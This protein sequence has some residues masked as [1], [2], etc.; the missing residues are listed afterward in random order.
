MGQPPPGRPTTQRFLSDR[1]L[2]SVFGSKN[3]VASGSVVFVFMHR[4]KH[5]G[6]N[7][8][9][10]GNV[11]VRNCRIVCK[12]RQFCARTCAFAVLFAWLS[13]LYA[14]HFPQAVRAMLCLVQLLAG[15]LVSEGAENAR[16]P[17]GSAGNNPQTIRF[18]R[19]HRMRK[20]AIYGKGGTATDA[21]PL[22]RLRDGVAP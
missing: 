7:T 15:G 18:L 1:L 20:S 4:C 8:F 3:D 11:F 6:R 17:S 5:V 9:L 21:S 13:S 19:F 14:L 16:A 10:H 22:R 2:V 12:V